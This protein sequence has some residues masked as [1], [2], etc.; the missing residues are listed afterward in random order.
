MHK[1]KGD[2]FDIVF[3][4]QLTEENYP[5][6]KDNIK[7]KSGGHF[8]ETIKSNIQN[9]KIKTPDEL[10]QEQIEETL[11]LLYVGITRAKK[12]LILTCS[13]NYKIRKNVKHNIFIEK[14]LAESKNLI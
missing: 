12:G 7:L 2:E 6:Q 5:T 9:Y 10:K 3:I 13:K 11:R 8:V 1:S 4:P 14:L